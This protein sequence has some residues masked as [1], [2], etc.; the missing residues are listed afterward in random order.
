MQLPALFLFL[1]VHSAAMAT[2]R[3]DENVIRNYRRYYG[4][5]GKTNDFRQKRALPSSVLRAWE[6]IVKTTFAFT[7]GKSNTKIFA[8]VGTYKKAK[9][10]F[11]A[12]TSKKWKIIPNIG[13]VSKTGNQEIILSRYPDYTVIWVKNMRVPKPQTHLRMV[14][15]A[16]NRAKTTAVVNSLPM[17]TNKL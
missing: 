15:Y 8:K 7:F 17:V 6:S 9:A 16:K 14:V 12:L 3:N 10:D 11:D 2:E 1:L 13:F 4:D 5:V